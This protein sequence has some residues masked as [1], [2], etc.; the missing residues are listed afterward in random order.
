MEFFVASVFWL[1][2]F[3]LVAGVMVYIVENNPRAEAWV[4]RLADK[5]GIDL[6]MELEE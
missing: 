2:A 5:L 3:M 6:D 1:S 4:E